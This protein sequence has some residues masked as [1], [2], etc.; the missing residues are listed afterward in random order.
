LR[1]R[2]RELE[3]LGYVVRRGR[4]YLLAEKGSVLAEVLSQL[5]ASQLL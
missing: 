4:E 3:I 1:D 2:L 5:E